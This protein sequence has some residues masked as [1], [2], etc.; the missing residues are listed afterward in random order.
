M[1]LMAVAFPILPGK[2]GEWRTWMEELNG[3][4]GE[5]FAESRRRAG[6]H[7]PRVANPSLHG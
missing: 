4:R 1:P 7:L 6:V 2:T 5:D 3:A